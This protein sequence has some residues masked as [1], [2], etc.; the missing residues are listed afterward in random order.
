MYGNLALE[1]INDGQNEYANIYTRRQRPTLSYTFNATS[2]YLYLGQ[3]KNVLSYE[4]PSFRSDSVQLATLTQEYLTTY[5]G[6]W[7]PVKCTA[8]VTG[9]LSCTAQSAA[10]RF[11]PSVTYSVFVVVPRE[12]Q[13]AADIFLYAANRIDGRPLGATQVTFD[14]SLD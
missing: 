4:I 9:A 2:G 12:G 7:S 13:S 1:A 6:S 5:P 8:S 3:S 11:R 14:L 10:T